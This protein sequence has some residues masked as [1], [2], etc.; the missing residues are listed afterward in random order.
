MTNLQPDDSA[1][2]LLGML[3]IC[4][5]V[6]SV[7][8]AP[9]PGL[10]PALSGVGVWSC[11]MGRRGEFAAGARICLWVNTIAFCAGVATTVWFVHRHW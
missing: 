6:G 3:G 8:M 10:G 5:A 2:S 9:V 7:V 4:L 11:W 1:H